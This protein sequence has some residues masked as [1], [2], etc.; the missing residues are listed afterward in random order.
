MSFTPR[1]ALL[2]LCCL[3]SAA[4]ATSSAGAAETQTLDTPSFT[5]T[6]DVRCE[7]GNV[8]C[9]DVRYVGTSKKTGKAMRLT[10]RTR[11]TT[12]A[13]GVTPCRFLGYEFKNGATVY[14]LSDGGELIVEQRGKPLLRE[15]GEWK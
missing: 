2:T 1:R 14:F 7:E 10:G 9:D 12:C 4:S 5:I 6:I 13:D 3:V 11:H 15:Q 8:T